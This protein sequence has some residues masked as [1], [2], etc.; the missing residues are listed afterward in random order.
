MHNIFES[1]LNNFKPMEKLME[2]KAIWLDSPVVVE[3]EN[4][5]LKSK[6]RIEKGMHIRVLYG[7][8]LDCSEENKAN[9]TIESLHG[10]IYSTQLEA[11]LISN[12]GEILK[13]ILK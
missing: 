11:H 8:L 12:S 6:V 3:L 2:L 4:G 13:L 1:L 9:Y 10:D 5:E 7:T